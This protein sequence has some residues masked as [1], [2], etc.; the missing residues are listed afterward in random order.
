MNSHSAVE[1]FFMRMIYHHK[2]SQHGR[3]QLS[4]QSSLYL[5]TLK[6]LFPSSRR[7]YW[8]TKRTKKGKYLKNSFH[9]G[10][11]GIENSQSQTSQG[12]FQSVIVLSEVFPTIFLIWNED[13]ELQ[14]QM[15]NCLTPNCWNK[16]SHPAKILQHRSKFGCRIWPT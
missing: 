15:A 13:W 1:Y 5:E 3:W 16:N 12:S 6:F 8:R 4:H 11:I 7:N 2:S 14:L 10:V 9:L